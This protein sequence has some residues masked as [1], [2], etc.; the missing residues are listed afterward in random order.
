MRGSHGV[1]DV[2]VVAGG[3]GDDPALV[4]VERAGGDRDGERPVLQ[5]SEHLGLVVPSYLA[6]VRL[7]D[8]RKPPSAHHLADPA[9]AIASTQGDGDGVR[10]LTP[11]MQVA[12]SI[13]AKLF[14]AL[15]VSQGDRQPLPA[16]PLAQHWART[17]Q[18]AV[19]RTSES[20]PNGLPA[21][22]R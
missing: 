1:I 12:P 13:L 2:R 5:P 15:A 20:G 8:Q 18:Q 17:P 21:G 22:S 7:R 4:A 9:R 19:G 16:T 6:V 14:E 10:K 3:A 11:G